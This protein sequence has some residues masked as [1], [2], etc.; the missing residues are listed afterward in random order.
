MG[1]FSSKSSSSQ[2]T[3]VYNTS[4]GAD[5]GAIAAAGGSVVNVLD[6]GA[7]NRSLDLGQQSVEAALATSTAQNEQAFDFAGGALSA[8]NLSLNKAIDAAFAF[9]KDAF[10]FVDKASTRA[11]AS[12]DRALSEALDVQDATQTGGSERLLILGGLA[13]AALVA[14]AFFN[15]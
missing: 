15:R 8:T 2:Q 12:A 7:V 14:V 9:A 1:L 5:E 10:G 3:S 4:T 6:A 13:V 11:V